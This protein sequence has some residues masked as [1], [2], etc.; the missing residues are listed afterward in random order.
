MA[1]KFVIET[2]TREEVMSELHRDPKVWDKH[3]SLTPEYQESLILYAMGK[4]GIPVTYDYVFRD[5]F[6]PHLYP[7]R[8][9]SLLSAILEREVHIVTILDREGIHLSENASFVIM[10]IVVWTADGEYIN[11]EMQKSGYAFPVARADCYT[12]DMIMRQ[13]DRIK[14]SLKKETGTLTSSVPALSDVILLKSFFIID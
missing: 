7:E 3:C 12:A 2:K 10:D 9:E 1:K 13:Y 14:K 6:D 5:I 11:V 8:L 4:R